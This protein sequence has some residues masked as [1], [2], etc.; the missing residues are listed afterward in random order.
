MLVQDVQ[1]SRMSWYSQEA[2]QNVVGKEAM[3]VQDMIEM[4]HHE[5]LHEKSWLTNSSTILFGLRNVHI[6][7][8]DQNFYFV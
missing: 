1:P 8:M 4:V 3:N 5:S 7:V 6:I 2:K